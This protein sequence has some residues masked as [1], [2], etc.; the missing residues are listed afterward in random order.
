MPVLTQSDCY[1][2][3]TRQSA[4]VISDFYDAELKES[5]LTTPQYRLLTQLRRLGSANITRWAETVGLDRSTMVRNVKLLEAKGL[6]DQAEG[7]GKVLT[8]SPRGE[9]ALEA[10]VPLWNAAQEKIASFLGEEDSQAIL[11][12]A[13][14][15]Q[16]LKAHPQ[17]E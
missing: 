3:N 12:I 2:T 15:L 6:L 5:G 4:N 13:S 8:L 9:A 10:A 14:K 7:H 16:R 17:A 1:C 11:R